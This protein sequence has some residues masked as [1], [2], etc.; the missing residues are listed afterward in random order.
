MRLKS[1]G[2]WTEAQRAVY[3]QV[4][5]VTQHQLPTALAPAS[6]VQWRL[7][8]H[9]GAAGRLTLP[10]WPPINDQMPHRTRS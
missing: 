5:P 3:L 10:L 1:S 2:G 8:E 6:R 9:V 7:Q 4:M